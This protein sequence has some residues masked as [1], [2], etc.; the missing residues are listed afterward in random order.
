[1]CVC[2]GGGGGVRGRKLCGEGVVQ[3]GGGGGVEIGGG[4]VV[5]GGGCG[6]TEPVHL[7]VCYK[8]NKR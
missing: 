6:Q 1:M 7:F 3:V 2:V 4:G 5:G 8:P